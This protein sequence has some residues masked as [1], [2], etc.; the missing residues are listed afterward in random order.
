MVSFL[1]TSEACKSETT[2]IQLDF[3]LSGIVPKTEYPSQHH[4]EGGGKWLNSL[5]F[6]PFLSSGESCRSHAHIQQS[7]SAYRGQ[8][9]WSTG[10]FLLHGAA[11]SSISLII[12]D[13]N[14]PGQDKLLPPNIF[15]FINKTSSGERE[16]VGPQINPQTIRLLRSITAAFGDVSCFRRLTAQNKVLAHTS[17]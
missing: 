6:F 3:T 15:Y 10:V 14:T 9:V 12:T 13:I 1:T 2:R 16:P 8:K 11:H 5:V 17:P 7:N 4:V